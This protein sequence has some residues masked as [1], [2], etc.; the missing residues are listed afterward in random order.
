MKTLIGLEIHVELSTKTKM[1]CSC[2]NEFGK[3]ANTNVC[4]ICLGHPGTLPK[5]N[6]RAV[7][8]AVKAGLALSTSINKKSRM[9][10]KKYFYSD[11]V[12]GFQ[13]SQDEIP[14]C[15]DGYIEIGPYGN[16]KKIRIQ[17]IHIEEDTG[18]SLHTEEGETLM[19]YNRS[20][21]PLIEIVTYPDISSKEEARE[22][23]TILK[24]TLKYIGV[25]DVKMEEGSLRCDVNINLVDGDRKTGI[26][27]IKNIN[28]FKAV[29][30]AIAFEEERQREFLE[31]GIVEVKQTRRWDDLLGETKLMRTKEEKDDYRYSY[32]GDLGELELSDEFIENIRKNLPELPGERLVRF[33]KDY[34]LSEYDADII[35]KDLNISRYFEETLDLT[36]DSKRTANWIISDVLRNLN[37]NE[38]E[39]DEL[40][41]T[42]KNLAT[43][44]NYV[45]E[46]KVNTNTAKKLLKEFFLEDVDIEKVIK[47]RGLIQIQD[48]D[49][50]LKIVEEV[51]AEN[52]QSII[53]YKNGKDR[54]LGFLVGMCM[55]KSKGKGNPVKFNEIILKKLEEA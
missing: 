31:K 12:K 13:I 2:K 54:A 38:M 15:R 1:F 7:E 4:E 50:L 37:E 11:L 3:P 51:L 16:K 46:D 27:E 26:A 55:K 22:F 8:Y 10:R 47:E 52:E 35:S 20:G 21:V 43:L 28:S 14:L 25:S 44:I 6:K 17:R 42:S 19:D 30:K 24:Q 33:I 40:K 48:E 39:S 45:K 23:L 29:Q 5:I 9:D 49:F 36:K 53:D 41:F 18:K 32:E 34:G